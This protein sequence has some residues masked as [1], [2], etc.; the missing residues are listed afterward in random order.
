[1]DYSKIDIRKKLEKDKDGKYVYIEKLTAKTCE[2]LTCSHETLGR[3]LGVSK[4][5]V[6]KWFKGKSAPKEVDIKIMERICRSEERVVSNID[7]EMTVIKAPLYSKGELRDLVNS[8][9]VDEVLLGILMM[10]TRNYD[11]VNGE[12]VWKDM[13]EERRRFKEMVEDMK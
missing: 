9:S 3:I 1:M 11:I 2:V 6:Q 12:V 4:P 5:L 13:E 7:G 10:T 8:V